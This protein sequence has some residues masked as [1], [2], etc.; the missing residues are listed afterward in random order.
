MGSSVPPQDAHTAI[1]S[2][3]ALLTGAQSQGEHGQA[4]SDHQGP[5]AASASEPCPWVKRAGS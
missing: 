5:F 3:A 1:Q 2:V 4:P